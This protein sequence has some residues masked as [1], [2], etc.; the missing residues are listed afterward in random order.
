MSG[1]T[2]KKQKNRQPNNTVET[3]SAEVSLSDRA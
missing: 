2:I 1:L 3:A